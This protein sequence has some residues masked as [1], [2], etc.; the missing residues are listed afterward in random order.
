M[1]DDAPLRPPPVISTILYFDPAL[2]AELALGAD[3]P[4]EIAERYGLDLVE[5][6]HL[7]AQPWF[8][9]LVARKR[10]EYQDDGVLFVAK[11]AMMAESLLTRLFQQAMA[12]TLTQPLMVEVSKQLSDIG[13]LK[14]QPAGVRE[15]VGPPFQINIQVNGHDVIQR[16]PHLI[17]LPEAAETDA[18]MTLDFAASPVTPGGPQSTAVRDGLDAFP[19]PPT[20]LKVPDFDLR[21]SALVGTPQAVLAASGAAPQAGGASPPAGLGLP[22]PTPPP[23]RVDTAPQLG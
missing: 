1:A 7:A 2:V 5:Y 11:A 14:P 23:G 17:G 16:T 6:E 10:Q 9:E 19:P 20:G 15:A 18:T 12:G 8:E 4:H 3:H 22:N 13:R 21:P